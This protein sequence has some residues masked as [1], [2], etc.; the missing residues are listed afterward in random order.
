M[1]L[2]GKPRLIAV[3]IASVVVML[4]AFNSQLLILALFAAI[5]ALIALVRLVVDPQLAKAFR[6]TSRPVGWS[7]RN[8]GAAGWT[9]G[10]RCSHCN[11]QGF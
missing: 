3:V 7:C 4:V 11:W 6:G 10:S 2:R 5:V 1:S 8:C 9:P